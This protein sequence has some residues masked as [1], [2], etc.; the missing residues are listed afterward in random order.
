MNNNS[1]SIYISEYP[2]GKDGELVVYVF[3]NSTTYPILILDF[4]G[5]KF[6]RFGHYDISE[7]AYYKLNTIH[8]KDVLYLYIQKIINDHD[9]I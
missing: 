1:H 8:D 6:D 4:I 5:Y 9:K 2:Q 3:K 7:E